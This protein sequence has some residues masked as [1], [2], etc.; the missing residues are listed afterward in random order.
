MAK[1]GTEVADMQ[2]PETDF[3][4]VTTQFMSKQMLTKL[5]DEVGPNR[6]LLVCCGAFR[7]NASRFDNLTVKKIPKAVLKKCEWGHYDYSLEIENLPDAPPE[8]LQYQE[9]ITN[10][11]RRTRSFGKGKDVGPALFDRIET[12]G[13]E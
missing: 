6:S 10:G 3:I 7:C 9:E 11:T 12:K 2:S 13:G 4:Y 8:F 1:E 5:S